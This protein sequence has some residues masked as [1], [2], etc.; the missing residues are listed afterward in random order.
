MSTSSL[1]QTTADDQ[2][3]ALGSFLK[4]NLPDRSW[5]SVKDLIASGKVDINGLRTTDPGARLS[6][7]LTVHLNM[8]TPR[9]GT[10]AAIER[11]NVQVVFEDESLIIVNKPSGLSSIPYEGEVMDTVLDAIRRHWKAK[12]ISRQMLRVVHRIDRA[13][14]GL[15]VMARTHA[16]EK[17]LAKQFRAHTIER[18]YLCVAHGITPPELRIESR[19][20][21][22]RGD[23]LR[24][25]TQHPTLGKHAVTHLKTL[26]TLANGQASLCSIRLETGKTHQ[27]RIHLSEQ[28]N[29]LLG[30]QVYIRDFTKTGA[31]PLPCDRLLLHAA[32]L[33]FNHPITSRWLRFSAPPPAD[34]DTPL[35]ALRA[36]SAP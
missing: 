8:S 23:G 7:G 6:P 29:P 21:K 34:F 24:G 14:S 3:L 25:S 2:G 27:I 28:G 36:L 4:R 17:G 35:Q 31:T 5:R 15:L 10:P 19:L 13:T 1:W 12:A 16:A 9:I 18:E 26:E 32:T 20:V 33:G 22:D 30:E 11:Q